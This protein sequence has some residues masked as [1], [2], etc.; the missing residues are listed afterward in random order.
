M[1]T[2]LSDALYNKPLFLVLVH[3][4]GHRLYIITAFILTRYLILSTLVDTPLSVALHDKPLFL[5]LVHFSGRNLA[6][7]DIYLS[8]LLQFVHFSGHI[9][10]ICITH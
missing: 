8:A 6:I 9:A 5:G 2:P 7:L 1:D 4:S 10:F 3:F